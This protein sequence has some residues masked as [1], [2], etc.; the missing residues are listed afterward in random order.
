M[1]SKEYLR[2]IVSKE[3]RDTIDGHSKYRCHES[4]TIIG[5]KLNS[6][7]IPANVK[8]GLA[9]YRTDFVLKQSLSTSE[10]FLDDIFEN[11][12]KDFWLG[13]ISGLQD[14]VTCYHSWLEIPE[15]QANDLTVVDLHFSMNLSKSV[16]IQ[17]ILIIERKKDLQDNV[18]YL[19]VGVRLGKWIFF[20]MFPPMATKLRI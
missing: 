17:D 14:K 9:T 15:E 12:E 11:K 19:P 7:G 4:V 8:D 10:H 20:K 18:S 2:Q 6:L 3:K 1:V 16:I 13:I 5:K